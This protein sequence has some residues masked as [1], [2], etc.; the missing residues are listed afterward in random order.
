VTSENAGAWSSTCVGLR[1]CGLSVWVKTSWQKTSRVC[2]VMAAQSLL[3]LFIDQP[4]Y[5]AEDSQLLPQSV[6]WFSATR[7]IDELVYLSALRVCQKHAEPV[8][9]CWTYG[10]RV[11]PLLLG[12]TSVTTT[13]RD[14]AGIDVA[15]GA[16]TP[17]SR[18]LSCEKRLRTLPALTFPATPLFIQRVTRL[19]RKNR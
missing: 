16:T 8:A 3:S 18:E 5:R 15:C 14:T 6:Q 7:Y 13:R 10:T 17:A 11:A 4:K 12:T 1:S 2:V 9:E 19:E